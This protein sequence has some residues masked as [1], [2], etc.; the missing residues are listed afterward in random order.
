[1]TGLR[2]I[3]WVALALMA[4]ACTTGSVGVGYAP[5]YW[6]YGFRY[7]VYDHHYDHDVNID[8]NR[9]D[10]PRPPPGLGPNRPTTLPA[11]VPP[12]SHAGGMHRGGGRAHGG[13]GRRG[14]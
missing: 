13:G 12:R 4:G 7:S 3:G 5:G 8:I 6:D 14:R 11:R 10:R 1:M 9:P 2:T